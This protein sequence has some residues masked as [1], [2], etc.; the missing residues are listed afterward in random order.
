MSRFGDKV[1]A[2]VGA[3]KDSVAVSIS[4]GIDKLT[5][6]KN[7][8]NDELYVQSGELITNGVDWIDS[9]N[10]GRADGFECHEGSPSIVIDLQK[11]PAQKVL[12]D[13]DR[14][15]QLI[16]PVTLIPGIVYRL[17]FDY[18]SNATLYVVQRDYDTTSITT[19]I[20]AI[21]Y[22]SI[23]IDFLAV[24]ETGIK[25]FVNNSAQTNYLQLDN[26]YLRALGRL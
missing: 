26:L 18:K 8:G 1:I 6:A 2:T 14:E 24:A 10:D 4:A 20:G 13:L 9:N 17:S 21:N 12:V 19:E 23:S 25:F 22:V 3:G 7:S 15:G 16:V 11:G 5:A